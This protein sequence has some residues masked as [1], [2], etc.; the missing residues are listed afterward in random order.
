MNTITSVLL[1]SGIVA[2]VSAWGPLVP[3]NGIREICS[4]YGEY[5][6]IC[7]I[8]RGRKGMRE[9]NGVTIIVCVCNGE[10][11]D[12]GADTVADDVARIYG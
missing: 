8:P 9:E 6:G 1:I 5:T 4:Y 7:T 12:E 3:D 11:A 2:C 10:D